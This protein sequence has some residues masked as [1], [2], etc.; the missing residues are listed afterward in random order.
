ML[1]YLIIKKHCMLFLNEGALFV[2]ES[3]LMFMVYTILP[4]VVENSSAAFLNLNLLSSDFYTAIYGFVFKN[5][6]VK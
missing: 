4:Q 6:Q 1:V 3:F 5:Y 2:F